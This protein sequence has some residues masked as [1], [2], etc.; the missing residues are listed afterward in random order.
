MG[1]TADAER[2]G[3][4]LLKNVITVEVRR[5]PLMVIKQSNQEPYHKHIT[6]TKEQLRAAQV[7]GQSSKELIN[8][9]CERQGYKVIEIGKAEKKTISIDLDALWG[10]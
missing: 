3:G 8:R 10:E 5:F 9:L 2:N 1:K 7:V 4:K 6:I